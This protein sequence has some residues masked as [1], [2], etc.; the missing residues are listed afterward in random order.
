[1]RNV[2]GHYDSTVLHTHAAEAHRD[3]SQ[4]VTPSEWSSPR[5]SAPFSFLGLP[6]EIRNMIYGELVPAQVKLMVWKPIRPRSDYHRLGARPLQPL[7]LERQFGDYREYDKLLSNIAFCYSC[8]SIR[9]EI[10]EIVHSSICVWSRES[11][12][13]SILAQYDTEFMQQLQHLNLFHIFYSEVSEEILSRHARLKTLI[14]TLS[15]PIHIES[16]F[17]IDGTV[18]LGKKGVAR[19]VRHILSCLSSNLTKALSGDAL[20][21]DLRWYVS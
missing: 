12:T 20:N 9:T 4:A 13:N 10:R 16:E 21:L 6:A 7:V 17:S 1:M 8:K 18:Q 2:H 11:W 5:I 19:K 3:P 14:L 15:N